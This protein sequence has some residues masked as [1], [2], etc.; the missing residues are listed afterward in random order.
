MLSNPQVAMLYADK[1]LGEV[2][3][4]NFKIEDRMLYS[5][6]TVVARWGRSG[7]WVNEHKYSP[8]TSKQLYCLKAELK[9]RG[10]TPT[11]V[12]NGDFRLYA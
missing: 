8:T 5:Y 9:E 12:K 11:D 4:S 3:G 1:K 6:K 7:C 10:F 2:K